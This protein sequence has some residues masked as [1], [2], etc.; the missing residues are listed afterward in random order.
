MGTISS[1][2]GIAEYAFS[3]LPPSATRF[4][5]IATRCIQC[6]WAATMHAQEGYWLPLK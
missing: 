3:C 4:N 2:L 6:F 1:V 5:V